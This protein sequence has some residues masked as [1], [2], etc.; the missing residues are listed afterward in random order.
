MGQPSFAF[1]ARRRKPSLSIPWTRPRTVSLLETTVDLPSTRSNV[2]SD[3]TSRLPGGVPAL[4]SS[5]EN[6]IE[7]HVACAAARS[8]SGLV[9]PSACSVRDAQVTGSDEK[10]RLVAALT[11]PVPDVRSPSH[12]TVA[13]RTTAMSNPPG[14]YVRIMMAPARPGG[15]GRQRETDRRNELRGTDGYA[16]SATDLRLATL[17]D[18][19]S[20]S[21]R[22]TR[23]RS[24]I[25]R[26]SAAL[27]APA[28]RATVSAAPNARYAVR[29]SANA[30]TKPGSSIGSKPASQARA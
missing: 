4:A 19:P 5:L 30:S 26:K 3:E 16:G 22:R 18:T 15:S 27:A 8:S 2:T 11:V 12:F 28:G 29:A 1:S 20:R 10:T 6:D 7:K 21:W 25:S 14:V 9:L 17:C 23:T 24:E 13:R